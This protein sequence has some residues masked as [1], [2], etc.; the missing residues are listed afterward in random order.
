[1]TTLGI[2][3]SS[4]EMYLA[5]LSRMQKGILFSLKKGKSLASFFANENVM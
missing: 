1:M 2:P 5:R 3:S 4:L